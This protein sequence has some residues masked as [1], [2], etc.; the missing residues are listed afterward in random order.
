MTYTFFLLLQARPEWLALPRGE[1][2][3]LARAALS[4]AGFAPATRLR[5]F[6]AEAFSAMASDIV[7]IET[8]DPADYYF[9]IERLRDSALLATPYFTIVAIL[10]AI[11]NGFRLFEAAA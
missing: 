6:D 11:E 10:P 1:R 9:G 8:D 3:A 2:N 7:T 5:H 4:D